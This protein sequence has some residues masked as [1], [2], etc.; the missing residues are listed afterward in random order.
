[1]GR[2]SIYMQSRIN[3]HAGFTKNRFRVSLSMALRARGNLAG[4][5]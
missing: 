2:N 5:A 4:G 3:S 1:M